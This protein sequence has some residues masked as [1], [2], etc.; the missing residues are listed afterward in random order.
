MRRG[1]DDLSQVDEV[2]DLR[3]EDLLP[4]EG[5]GNSRRRGVLSLLI[6]AGDD[7]S[8]GPSPLRRTATFGMI[9]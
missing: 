5:G 8:K 6:L 9:L 4:P 3:P 7:G 1:L 2:R